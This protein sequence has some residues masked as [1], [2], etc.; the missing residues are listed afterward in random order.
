MPIFSTFSAGSTTGLGRFRKRAIAVAIDLYAKY[1]TLLLNG[2]GTNNAQNNTFLD[3]SGY[4]LSTTRNGNATQGTFSPFSQPNGYWSN[5]FDGSSYLTEPNAAWMNLGTGNF[6]IECWVQFSSSVGTTQMF[7]SNNYNAGN[8]AGGWAFLY[9]ADN[10]TLK[11]TCNSNVSYEKTWSP[12]VGV[13]YHVAVCRSGTDLRLFVDGVQVGTTSTSSDNIS[14]ASSTLVVG[15]NES[16]PLP[17]TGYLSNLR[18]VTSA[19]YTANFTPST[20]PLTVVSET[21]ILTCQSN[22]FIDNSVNNATITTSGSPS[23]QPFSPF[24]PTAAYSAAT[25]G[26]SYYGDGSGDYLL[27][28]TNGLNVNSGT[29][30]TFEC[31]LY[32]QSTFTGDQGTCFFAIGTEAANRIQFAMFGSAIRVEVY[33]GT[34]DFNGGTV[35]LN[36]W[37]HV[38]IVRSGTT[39]TIYINGV[40][41]TSATWNN[42]VGNSGGFIV[43]AN[44]SVSNYVNGY[45]S[46]LRFLI[47]TALYTSNFTPPTSPPTAISNTYL[48]LNFTNAGI[49]DA[50]SKNN[51]ETVG[52]V[53]ISTTQSKFGGS[54]IY[55]DG[56]GDRIYTVNP[57]L[58]NTGDFTLEMW[59]Y[60]TSTSGYQIIYSQYTY[61]S[62][63]GNF[64][65]LWDEFNEKFNVNFRGSTVLTS[66]STYALNTWHHLAIVRYGSALTMYVNGTSADTT[67]NSL[68]ILQTSS[69]IGTRSLLDGYFNGYIDDLRVT[70]YAIYKSDF[71]VPSAPFTIP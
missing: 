35:P 70:K 64:E 55:F 53:K 38:A 52:D 71:S 69:W 43:G 49:Y 9:R 39:I 29:D 22:R 45:I 25:N 24:E 20:S 21:Q 10:T 62:S 60:P 16:N 57:C 18:I 4:N 31:W 67:T 12:S 54:A 44:R 28:T 2:N 15:S 37:T 13:I 59:I 23:V 36:A 66:S 40:S 6:T 51:L 42:V 61:G 41:A 26:G 68:S 27:N 56:T 48:L 14:G 17:I 32:R 11:F 19:L 58:P 47:G 63:D 5:Y 8:G 50:S 1:V 30:F 65:L 34:L 46:G 3:S 7:V 33:A